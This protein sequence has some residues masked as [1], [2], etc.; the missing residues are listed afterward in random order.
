M[1]L[2]RVRNNFRT[3]QVIADFDILNDKNPLKDIYEE[4]SG[5]WI[6]IEKDWNMVKTSID[7]KRPDLETNEFRIKVKTLL[8]SINGKI[9]PKGTVSEIK[10]LLKKTS[11]WSSAK[12]VGK[13]FI[14]NGDPTQAYD[15]VQAKLSEKGLYI[16]EVGQ[17]ESF[18][19]SIG[20]HGPKWVNEVVAKNLKTDSD[21]EIAR[22]FVQRVIK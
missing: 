6:D 12:D 4:L 14:P 22:Q 3:L 5:T 15:R 19:K 10:E 17:L 7:Q 21:L 11:A 20:N 2:G 9:V 13:Q 16:V 18:C 8:D 1:K